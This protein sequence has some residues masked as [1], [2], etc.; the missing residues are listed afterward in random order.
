M[1]ANEEVARKLALITGKPLT[2][3][4]NGPIRGT[5]EESE[6]VRE[7]TTSRT[8]TLPAQKVGSDKGIDNIPGDKSEGG[9]DNRLNTHSEVLLEYQ[10]LF[11]GSRVVNDKIMGGRQM[12][13][14]EYKKYTRNFTQDDLYDHPLHY[15]F[16]RAEEQ[17]EAFYHR[18][19]N[20]FP[21]AEDEC[22]E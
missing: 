20:R 17:N 2:E 13:R 5:H 3:Y 16:F 14:K 6:G 22:E 11:S 18:W 9:E 19:I 10:K 15:K 12:T 21:E 7:E 8:N 4:Y 1:I